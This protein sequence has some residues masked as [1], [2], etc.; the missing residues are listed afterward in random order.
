MPH[1]SN[2][3]RAATATVLTVGFAAAG[4]ATATA[5]PNTTGSSADV[6]TLAASLPKGYGLNNCQSAQIS[7][8][9]KAELDCG[10]NPDPSGPKVGIYVL[11]ASS[12]DASTPRPW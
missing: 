8:G 12:T 4:A 9:A 10:Q 6:N 2:A 5:D 7:G 3:L 1:L 11:Y